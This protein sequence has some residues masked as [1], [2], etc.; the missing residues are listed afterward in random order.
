MA[1]HMINAIFFTER[2]RHR[3]VGVD[4]HPRQLGDPATDSYETPAREGTSWGETETEASREK[5][6]ASAATAKHKQKQNIETTRLMSYLLDIRSCCGIWV[7]MHVFLIH[8]HCQIFYKNYRKCRKL[9]CIISCAARCIDFFL[10]WQIKLIVRACRS[11]VRFDRSCRR[12]LVG[13]FH[14]KCPT[15]I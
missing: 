9:F 2:G 15:N 4:D 5:S 7:Y 14:D 6:P 8:S 13:G 10:F 1:S 11:K 3:G 12:S